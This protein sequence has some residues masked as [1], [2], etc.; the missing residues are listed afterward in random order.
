M[1]RAVGAEAEDDAETIADGMEGNT[2]R[3]PLPGCT[4]GGEKGGVWAGWLYGCLGGPARPA[5]STRALMFDEKISC[6]QK[7]FVFSTCRG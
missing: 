5:V 4:A 1:L 2:I 6:A 3:E 7:C